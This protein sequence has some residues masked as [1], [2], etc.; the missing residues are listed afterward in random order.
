MAGSGGN[1]TTSAAVLNK[2]NVSQFLYLFLEL[3]IIC[4]KGGEKEWF[5]RSYE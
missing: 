4:I 3:I 2:S 1:P 5:L